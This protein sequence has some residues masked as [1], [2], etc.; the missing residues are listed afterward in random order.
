MKILVDEKIALVEEAFSSIGHVKSMSG[1][2]IN[3]EAI[4]DIDVLVTRTTTKVD[5]NLLHTSKVKFVATATAGI[6]HIDLDYLIDHAI[7]FASA[8]GCNS[9]A[10][11]EYV[12]NA[13]LCLAA[14]KSISLQN[15]TIGI[16]GAGNAGT[17]LKKKAECLGFRCLLNDPPL[18]DKSKNPEYIG[19][20][21]LVAQ[22]DII[23]LHVPLTRTGAYPTYHLIDQKIF[24]LIRPGTIL[25]NT[26]RGGVINESDLT[27]F[28]G[29]LAGLILD[30]WENEP[31]I[32]F[33]TLKLADI[34]TPHIAGYSLDGKYKATEIIYQKIC[35]H[36]RL[37][38]TWIS[39][40]LQRSC[41]ITIMPEH[42]DENRYPESLI[43]QTYDIYR[44]DSRLRQ[45]VDQ[46][47]PE[48]YFRSLRNQ[49]DFRSEFSNFLVLLASPTSIHTRQLLRNL[50]F[51]IS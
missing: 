5:R 13:L 14:A 2:E 51:L 15:K 33:N 32:D 30:V 3:P 6:D 8:A 21:D 42:P 31:S 27:R 39:P 40:R 43:R 1:S 7:G 16:I 49:Y 12:V 11:A 25:L 50:G 20:T 24:K 4:A 17:A 28:R 34:A 41:P 23:S 10:V 37:N 35:D 44:D 36:F 45:I 18:F 19:L 22:S 26:S 9:I 48:R 29:R 47:F 38:P 46:Q